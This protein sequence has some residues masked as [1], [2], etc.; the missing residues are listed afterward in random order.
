MR[1]LV[2]GASGLLGGE[3]ARQLVH[4]G[5]DVA[6]FQRRSS[7]VD[8]VEDFR[9]SINDDAA[10]RR[11]VDGAEGLIHLAAK[12]SIT[13]RPAQFQAVNVEGTRSLLHHA[14]AAG[15]RDVVYVS[16]PSVAHSGA[17]IMGAGAEKADPRHARGDY[18][19]TKAEAELLALAADGSHLRVAGV[20]PHIV[21]GPGDTQLVERVLARASHGRL[22]LLDSG[23]A[24]IDTTYV[25]NAAS[26]IVAALHR[27]EHVHGKAVVVSNGEPR[28]IGELLSGICAAGGVAPP[29]WSVPGGL[30]RAAGAV[31]ERVWTWAG[32]KEEP[33]MTRFLAEQLS[34]AHWFDQRL[35]RELLN[36][37]P[38]VSVDEGLARL[39]EYYGS[40]T[41]VTGDS[42]QLR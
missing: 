35:T 3:V 28:P 12:V 17:A 32:R 39:T 34:T 18:A 1:V 20:R 38:D 23:A 27:M 31:V 26:A 6:S 16:S 42:G 14:K 21:W 9:G 41:S 29:S 40:R 22:P 36:W 5:H 10:L 2:T 11:A 37:T 8:G 25:D 15:V 33:P 13:G 4:Q 24:L 19:R 7:G 30:A